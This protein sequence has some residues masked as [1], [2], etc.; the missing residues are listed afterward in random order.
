[1]TLCSVRIWWSA[2]VFWAYDLQIRETTGYIK[3]EERS[4][5]VETSEDRNK[6]PGLQ[7][8]LLAG[9]ILWPDCLYEV[10]KE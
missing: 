6:R 5:N 1:M 7:E 3:E 9:A 4:S 2:E 8:F 10:V